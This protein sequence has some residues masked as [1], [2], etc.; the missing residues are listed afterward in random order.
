[1]KKFLIIIVATLLLISLLLA[2]CGGGGA[3]KGSIIG[4]WTIF[5]KNG[6]AIDDEF[7]KSTVFDFTADDKIVIST[8]DEVI[9]TFFYTTEKASGF[10]KIIIT[11]DPGDTV[12]GAF[13]FE[14]DGKVLVLKTNYSDN[15]DED[16]PANMDA[17]EG[18]RIEKYKPAATK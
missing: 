16:Y 1:M 9:A 2:S 4:K 8:W 6:K 15:K 7:T 5:E 11:A 13:S 18:F 3:P 10:T 12:Y 17:E 14:D